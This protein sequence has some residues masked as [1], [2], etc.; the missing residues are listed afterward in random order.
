MIEPEGYRAGYTGRRDDQGKKEKNTGC[1]RSAEAAPLLI[2][3]VLIHLSDFEARL[4]LPSLPKESRSN[5]R[6]EKIFKVNLQFYR[7]P[8]G[9]FPYSKNQVKRKSK[10]G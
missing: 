10:T 4:Y 3:R 5:I 8:D 2:I 7:S 9:L 1:I 6:V